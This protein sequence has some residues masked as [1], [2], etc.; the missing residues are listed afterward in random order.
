MSDEVK[1]LYRSKDD[2]WLGGVC[3][4]LAQYLKIDA[5][6]VRVIF[7]ILF[8]I[9][10]GGILLYL[11]MWIIIPE[12]PEGVVSAEAGEAMEEAVEE[13]APEEEPAEEE[14]AEEEA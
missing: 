6:I 7:I 14:P 12:E 8:L 4:G 1:R 13:M 11:L 9:G 2:R 5:T 3:G 10:G